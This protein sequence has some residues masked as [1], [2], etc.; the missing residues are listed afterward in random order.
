V[1]G[2]TDAERV[3]VNDRIAVIDGNGKFSLIVSL[4][5]G[6][7]DL[8]VQATDQA[9]NKTETTMSVTYTP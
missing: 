6:K 1:E 3:T 8:V 5:E 9:G 2:I 4:N 7:N